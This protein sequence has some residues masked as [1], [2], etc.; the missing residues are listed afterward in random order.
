MAKCGQACEVYSRVVGYFRPTTN[1]NKGKSAE[2]EERTEFQETPSM[3]NKL[4]KKSIKE[5]EADR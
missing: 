3:M 1:W 2:F 4:C 5:I